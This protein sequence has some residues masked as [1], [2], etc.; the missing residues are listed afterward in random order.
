MSRTSPGAQSDFSA[1]LE[2]VFRVRVLLTTF[3]F[4]L[5][6]APSSFFLIRLPEYTHTDLILNR[7]R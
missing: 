3:E 2:L 6:A 4:L 7:P 1:V 5:S